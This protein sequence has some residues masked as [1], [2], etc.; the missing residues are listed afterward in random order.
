MGGGTMEGGMRAGGTMA[1][2]RGGET[3]TR[4][5]EDMN[6]SSIEKYCASVLA[7]ETAYP[8]SVVARCRR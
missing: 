2:R 4:S 5:E 1:G 6:N 8:S 3:G 7:D